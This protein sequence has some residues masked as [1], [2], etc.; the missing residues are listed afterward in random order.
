VAGF[1]L[2]Q[3][4]RE[5]Y[6]LF[7]CN[8]ILFNHESPRR[9]LEF[10]TRKITTAVACIKRGLA[11]E[12]PLGNLDAQRDWGHAADYVRA[13]H[14]MLQQP[15]PDDY[16]VATGEAHSVREFCELAFGALN[17]DYRQYVKQDE[18]LFRPA[19]VEFLQGD[20][21]KARTHLGWKPGYTFR[22]LVLEMV[23]ED[24]RL[25]DESLGHDGQAGGP[26][27][28]DRPMHPALLSKC[29]PG[30]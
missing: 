23:R 17:L 24:L 4:Y 6:G 28:M 1:H 2:T 5:A 14:L 21:S 30:R 15:A 11:S 3:N 13:M 7:C 8:G 12:L 16:V 18:S 22:E 25:L 26:S 29:S 20:A 9:G 19:E 10:V 27:E